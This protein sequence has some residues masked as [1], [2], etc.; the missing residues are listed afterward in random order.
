MKNLFAKSSTTKLSHLETYR[1]KNVANPER[2]YVVYNSNDFLDWRLPEIALMSVKLSE[3]ILS[4]EK[5]NLTAKAKD[6]H[7]KI[8]QYY[9]LSLLYF[10]DKT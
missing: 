6:M 8:H 5:A 2:S 3:R 4:V 10:T 1:K 9:S 7:D